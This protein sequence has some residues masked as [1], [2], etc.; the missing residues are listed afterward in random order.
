MNAPSK[1]AGGVDGFYGD[2]RQ[3]MRREQNEDHLQMNR[4]LPWNPFVTG[5]LLQGLQELL[6][7]SMN[8]EATKDQYTS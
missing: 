2:V 4:S 5:P 6:Q 7:H 1:V 8:L 3:Q